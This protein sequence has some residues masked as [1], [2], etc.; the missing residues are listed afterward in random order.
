MPLTQMTSR[1]S[2][3]TQ[4]SIHKSVFEH[5]I[6][7]NFPQSSN[8]ENPKTYIIKRGKCTEKCNLQVYRSLQRMNRH[9]TSNSQLPRPK[10]K[11]P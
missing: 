10:N 7:H 11:E 8:K 6:D 4:F 9:G 5:S 1:R 2:S 3:L